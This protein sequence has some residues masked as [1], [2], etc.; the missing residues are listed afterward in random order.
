MVCYSSIEFLWLVSFAAG[1]SVGAVC[2]NTVAPS[3]VYFRPFLIPWF[4]PHFLTLL[5]ESVELW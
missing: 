1:N 5:L 3:A 4:S 2:Q